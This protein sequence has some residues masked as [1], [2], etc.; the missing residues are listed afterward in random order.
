[1]SISSLVG[2]HVN[3]S[4]SVTRISHSQEK[5]RKFDKR[6]LSLTKDFTE[7]C[8][9]EKN[10]M[11]KKDIETFFEKTGIYDQHKID[12]IFEEFDENQISK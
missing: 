9:N 7:L 1:M 12:T 6:V 2:I 5:M 8:G 11:F 4:Q 10:V 3:D